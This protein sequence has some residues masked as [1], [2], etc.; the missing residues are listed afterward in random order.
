MAVPIHP[1]HA[2][3]RHL[4]LASVPA[5]PPSLRLAAAPLLPPDARHGPREVIAP[6]P[7]LLPIEG[8]RSA[9]S[10]RRQRVYRRRRTAVVLGLLSIFVVVWQL[11]VAATVLFADPA[12]QA[13]EPSTPAVA[14]PVTGPTY[15]VQSGDTLWSIARRISPERDPRPVVDE[16]SSRVGGQGLRPGQQLDVRDIEP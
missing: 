8:G 13:H 15:V 12:P 1:H 14:M 3:R 4:R 7:V 5:A 9:A 16:L 10:I 11:A 2:Q 6:R